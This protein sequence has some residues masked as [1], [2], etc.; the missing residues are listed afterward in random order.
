MFKEP[1]NL[2]NGDNNFSK[3][4]LPSNCLTNLYMIGDTKDTIYNKDGKII[5]I[6]V[7]HNLVVNSFLNLAMCL[8][9]NEDDY[10]GIKY[11]AVGTGDSTWDEKIPE[12]TL[13]ETLL[14]NE[15]GRV[16]I[17]KNEIVFLDENYEISEVPTNII[18]IVHVF[19]V[20]DCNG[21]WREFGLFGGNATDEKN[22]GI[23]VNKRHH[24]IITKTEDM[25]IERTMRFTLNFI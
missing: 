17:P 19:G 10:T 5:D 6:I 23:L 9:K 12:P 3:I 18:Q 11:W 8:L 16:E 21:V 13:V 20:H 1:V 22:S 15:L 25:V 4:I 7:G 24:G 14:T 2:K